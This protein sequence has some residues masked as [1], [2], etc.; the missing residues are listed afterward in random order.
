MVGEVVTV[1]LHV[2]RTT[3]V[4]IRHNLIISVEHHTYINFFIIRKWYD[5]RHLGP[6]LYIPINVKN[7]NSLNSV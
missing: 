6:D 2:V 5:D 4:T 7:L 3:T 1:G